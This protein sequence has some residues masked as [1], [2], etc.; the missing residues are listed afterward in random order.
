MFDVSALPPFAIF[1]PQSSIFFGCGSAAL[2]SLRQK[3]RLPCPILLCFCPLKPLAISPSSA[4]Q[5]TVWLI[6]KG[7]RVLSPRF[8]HYIFHGILNVPAL[9]GQVQAQPLQQF[10]H[11]PLGPRHGAQA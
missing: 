4:V 1:H 9:F 6:C 2:R 5:R 3:S 7:L 10:C 11:H 8:L